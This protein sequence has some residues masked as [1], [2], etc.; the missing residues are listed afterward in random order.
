M[1]KT[2]IYSHY[3]KGKTEWAREKERAEKPDKKNKM[4]FLMTHFQKLRKERTFLPLTAWLF[5]IHQF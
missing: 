4:V 1:N 2:K 5:K 3:I